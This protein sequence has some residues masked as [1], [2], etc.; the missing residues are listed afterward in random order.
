MHQCSPSFLLLCIVMHPPQSSFWYPRPP[1]RHHPAKPR[2]PLTSAIHCHL[3]PQSPISSIDSSASFTSIRPTFTFLELITKLLRAFT[4]D[5]LFSCTLSRS[6]SSLHNFYSEP[7]TSAVSSGNKSWFI[8][9][10]PQYART[11][12]I[13][14]FRTT[15]SIVHVAP[16]RQTVPVSIQH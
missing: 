4:S 16:R 8:S 2:Y 12:I 1:S 13:F 10:L 3:R 9:N 15:Q 7:A 6:L 11:P 14:K 5:F